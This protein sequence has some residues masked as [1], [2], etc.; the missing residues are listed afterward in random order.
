MSRDNEKKKYRLVKTLG[1]ITLGVILF[2]ILAVLFIRSPWGQH[3]ILDKLLVYI[4]DKTDTTIEVK[5]IFV[6]FSGNVY[7]EGIYLEDKKGDTL[8]YSKNLETSL[9]LLPLIRG[10]AL[11]IKSVD[12]TGF[13]S[14]IY[15]DDVSGKFN[16]DFLLEAFAS[17]DTVNT[18]EKKMDIT[19]R[20]LNF[21]D[22]QISYNDKIAQT[23]GE[24]TLGK[25]TADIDEFDL[26][27]MRFKVN[28]SEIRNSFIT[29]FQN[30]ALKNQ[31][32]TPDA[33]A[34][35]PFISVKELIIQHVQAQYESSPEKLVAH[36][37][38]GDLELSMPALNLEK[39]EVI[40]GNLEMDHS[41][42]T[43]KS[44]K[45]PEDNNT[46]PVVEWPEWKIVAGRLSWSDNEIIFQN[47]QPS[48]QQEQ[49]NPNAFHI[50]DFILYAEDFLIDNGRANL[51]LQS[52]SFNDVNHIQ[53]N[54]LAF[55]LEADNTF[56]SLNNFN[57]KTSRS[58]I[59]G[60]ATLTYSSLKTLFNN[61]DETRVSMNF[62]EFRTSVEE[63]FTF[64]PDLK[65]NYYLKTLAKKNINGHIE[66]TG[67]LEDIRLPNTSI[68]WGNSTEINISGNIY[69]LTRP[70]VF[71]FDLDN[72]NLKTDSTDVKM[73]LAENSSG[74]Y[75]PE[76][77]LLKGKLNG[78]TENFSG[79]ADL[80][81]SIG[82]IKV[83]G[84]FNS[85]N[86]ISF[87]GTVMTNSLDMEKIAGNPQM[88][89]ISFVTEVSGN[90]ANIKH[91]DAIMHTN[92]SKLGYGGYD[93]SALELNGKM[94]GGNG[95]VD[96]KFKDN[97]LN[98]KGVAGIKLDSVAPRFTLNAEVIGADLYGLGITADDIRTA[99]KVEG[100]YEGSGEEFNVN[101]EISK[102]VVVYDDNAYTVSNFKILGKVNNDS[103]YADINSRLI[104]AHFTANSNIKGITTAITNH[105]NGYIN[106][107]LQQDTI[108]NPVVM[109][110]QAIIRKTP[111]M[112]D[113]Y[114]QSLNKLDTVRIST[115]FNEAEKQLT[116]SVSAPFIQY[117]EI[118]L[119]SLKATVDSN[120]E[121][122]QFNIGWSQLAAAPLQ[123]KRTS[124]AGNVKENTVFLNFDA[125][126]DKEQLA[127]MQS[128]LNL[129]NDTLQVH[130]EPEG[131]ILNKNPW[132]I[133]SGN[134]ITAASDYLEFN[135]FILSR[136][137]QQLA[138]YSTIADNHTEKVQVDF[139]NFKLA[140]IMT[141]LNPDES[142]L[143][144]LMDG[145]F[146]VEKP[147][148][149]SG[150]VADINIR[151]LKARE[152]LLGNL[153]LNALSKNRGMYDFNLSVKGET[154]LDITGDYKAAETGAH[155][156]LDLQLNTLKLQTIAGLTKDLI[157][158]PEGYISG[159]MNIKGTT[160]H[161]VYN[162]TFNFNDAGLV[163]NSLNAKY[164]LSKENITIN[165]EGLYFENF[166]IA[167]V[168]ENTFRVDGNIKTEDFTNPSFDFTVKADNFRALNSTRDDNDLFYGTVEMN[169]DISVKG[170][171]E[172][173]LIRGKL[174]VNEGSDFTLVIPESQLDIVEREGVV[175]FVNRENPD[176]ILTRRNEEESPSATLKG[177]DADIDLV[178]GENAVFKI[179]IDERT[180]DNIQVSG[181]GDFDLALHPNGRVN[182]SGR[183]EVNDG[184]YEASLYNLVTRRFDLA[185][186]G[187]I[188]W[189][190]DPLDAQLDVRAIYRVE[191]SAAPLMATQTSA[192]SSAL[193]SKFRQELPFLVYLNV[194][195][196]LLQP[197][198][199]FNLDIPEDE[200]GSLGGEVYARVQQ[201]NDREE[202]LNKQVFSL[203]VLNRFF[204][205]SVSDGSAGGATSIARDNV[206]KV[207]SG[208]LNT[209]S[210]K[211]IGDTGIDLTFGLDSYT[212]YQ[213]E[214]PQN[215]TQL[216]ISASKKLFNDRLIVQAG[217]EVD[218]EGSSPNADEGSP[219]IGNLSL[220]YML[221]ENGRFRLKGFRKNEFESVI[222]G[223]LIVTGIAVI[224]NREFNKFSEL[225]RSSMKKEEE[226]SVK[227]SGKAD[228]KGNKK[229]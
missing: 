50:K 214:S 75:I 59:A 200:Q 220:E 173:P 153:K 154:D 103:T 116:A 137:Q 109:D 82:E 119:D 107:T 29:Y 42:I 8:L 182:L 69:N 179:I 171:L 19:L 81:T 127:H 229:G 227:Q 51:D 58:N 7:A 117:G 218:I 56:L 125:Y 26:Q 221:T 104:D 183:Y 80:Q 225:W 91:L 189:N 185:K 87:K 207:L 158:N 177:Y 1:K 155:L 86:G 23:K 162:G 172:V 199:S 144:G 222:D 15:R 35:L 194:D 176:A 211:I 94:T 66:A 17:P 161:P 226:I 99:F 196:E 139:E 197:E 64:Q 133:S 6:T 77:I 124:L 180:G 90:G 113:V 167:D 12:L 165:N 88:G 224:F 45:L 57:L 11:H 39:Q 141:Y 21:E 30:D 126:D 54:N 151:D 208:Q 112:E 187:S 201:L 67:T 79:I 62:P 2:F 142:L 73:F 108:G 202:E 147:F 123:V 122:L 213:G 41:N 65:N 74:V 204:P 132:N 146:T 145:E 53:L 47:R 20:T 120:R 114:I 121:S 160:A 223:Q 60:S 195:G 156:N 186:G 129:K 228:E 106:N 83:N 97:Y 184:H 100:A 166:T 96:I 76:K 190:G 216:D 210:D 16:Y 217:S 9:S 174:T 14:H 206:N 134:S 93:F 188:T 34:A 68:I 152:Q 98:L 110:L 89:K 164:H 85:S 135:N 18:S 49:F 52:F 143:N 5:K 205:G 169:A 175:I 22:I 61:P 140:T 101:A 170:N 219:I 10:T 46:S 157:S 38:L 92:F 71:T 163:I 63:V 111:P 102:G 212:D 3:I 95:N 192:Q 32:D 37:D 178:A 198:I 203:L 48:L 105:I 130:I 191:T 70:E 13:R 148:N 150:I 159:N 40:I 128:R 24:A 78:G 36:L 72:F 149:D 4:S 115:H 33:P 25:L 84:F 118:V 44:Y 28:Q 138:V 181:S 27:N 43:Y 215:R 209:L 193:A 168:S 131:L 31:P 136:N 55:T